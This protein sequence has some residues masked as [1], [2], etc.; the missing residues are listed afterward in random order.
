MR[1]LAVG[2][3]VYRRLKTESRNRDGGYYWLRDDGC[4]WLRISMKGAPKHINIA[5]KIV[6]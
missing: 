3:E 2:R 1:A 5:L 6:E 4:D